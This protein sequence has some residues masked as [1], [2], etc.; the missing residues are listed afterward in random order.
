[1]K[2]NLF[3]EFLVKNPNSIKKKIAI[4]YSARSGSYMLSGFLD[5]HPKLI[6]SIY[7]IENTIYN[8]LAIEIFKTNHVEISFF[9]LK[10]LDKIDQILNVNF[11]NVPYIAK[12]TKKLK[13]NKV[14]FIRIFKSILNKINSKN[15]TFDLAI[16]VIYISFGYTFNRPL[17]TYKPTIIIQKHVPFY[18]ERLIQAF[19]NLENLSIIIMVRNPI[20]ALDSMAYHSIVE[21]KTTKHAQVLNHVVN[22]YRASLEP[23]IFNNYYKKVTFIKFE[24]LHSDIEICMRKISKILG[25]QYIS[26]MNEETLFG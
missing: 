12:E 13:F 17:N 5:S 7:P 15:I 2:Q 10:F 21:H 4:T 11:Y 6:T 23:F 8:L 26:K 14:K 24:D 19:N 20:L 18:E 9:K 16:N 25:I 22:E 3:W 1:M